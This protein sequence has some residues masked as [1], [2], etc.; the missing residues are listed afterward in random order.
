MGHQGL[1]RRRT[2]RAGNSQDRGAKRQLRKGLR[3]PALAE[4]EGPD[5]GRARLVLVFSWGR[6]SLLCV[7]PSPGRCGVS[8]SVTP[9][10][11]V[12]PSKASLTII[13]EAL[14]SLVNLC[15][16]NGNTLGPCKKGSAKLFLPILP[17][18]EGGV[19]KGYLSLK[20]HAMCLLKH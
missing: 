19:R 7:P 9:F 11:H 10:P 8:Q 2:A 3:P 12:N 5:A 4:Q 17:S 6:S 1:R 15:L 13:T 18:A 16:M 20:C 14:P